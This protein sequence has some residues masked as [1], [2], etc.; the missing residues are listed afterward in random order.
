MNIKSFIFKHI[1]V[2]SPVP[3]E[4]FLT[5]ISPYTEEEKQE[6]DNEEMT[7]WLEYL[8]EAEESIFEA[9]VRTPLGRVFF[10]ENNS[11]GQKSLF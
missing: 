7:A 1:L 3:S 4:D 11:F 6:M 8:F 10:K 5:P 9:S 2:E